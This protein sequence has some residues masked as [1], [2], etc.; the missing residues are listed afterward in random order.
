LVHTD[1]FSLQLPIDVAITDQSDG[2]AVFQILREEVQGLGEP[3]GFEPSED[4]ETFLIVFTTSIV[5][6]KRPANPAG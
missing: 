5:H 1:K 2:E 4:G 3:T 6:W